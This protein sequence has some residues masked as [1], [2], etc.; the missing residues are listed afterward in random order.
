MASFR[1]G[2]FAAGL[3]KA[4][5]FKAGPSN[6]AGSD[7]AVGG[8][9]GFQDTGNG[10]LSKC[11]PLTARPRSSLPDRTTRPT[12]NSRWTQSAGPGSAGRGTTTINH[13]IGGQPGPVGAA[14]GQAGE[15]SR[16]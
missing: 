9:S 3:F 10:V 13:S 8:A 2:L 16:P 15:G 14:F 12:R 11:P 6:T 1:A 4:A 5:L 7:N